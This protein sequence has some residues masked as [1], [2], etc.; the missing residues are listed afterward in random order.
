MELET[1]KFIE[2]HFGKALT[3]AV[4]GAVIAIMAMEWQKT[5]AGWQS[6]V[7][8]HALTLASVMIVVGGLPALVFAFAALRAMISAS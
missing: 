1:F 2:Q 8:T 5:A 7:A 3:C 4:I 6:K